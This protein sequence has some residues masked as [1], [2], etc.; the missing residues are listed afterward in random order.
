MWNKWII[1]ACTGLLFAA[2][3]TQWNQKDAEGRKHGPWIEYTADSVF[4]AV[5]EYEHGEKVGQETVY[6]P[7]TSIFRQY[8][9]DWDS[10]GS[11]TELNG[12]YYHFRQDGTPV[13]EGFYRHGQPDSIVRLYYRDGSLQTKGQYENGYKTGIWKYFDKAGSLLKTVDYNKEPQ[14]WTESLQHGTI[15]Y[16][17]AGIQ[18]AYRAEWFHDNLIR[19][20]ILDTTAFHILQR[21]G[22]IDSATIMP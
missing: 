22:R 2:C 14:L 15:T 12:P 19:D 20:T 18:P 9:W 10:S 5:L 4:F 1:I 21:S 6:Y 17:V 11:Y 13:M 3:G 8:H 7:D 16:F